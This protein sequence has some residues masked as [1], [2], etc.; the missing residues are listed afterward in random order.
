MD[1][2]AAFKIDDGAGGKRAVLTG[3][4]TATHLGLA[5]DRLASQLANEER[6]DRP[7]RHRP[8]RH[9]R[10]LERAQGDR[11]KSRLG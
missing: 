7:D 6:D 5:P 8:M 11:R 2:A 9:L 10:R 1:E 3:D 4:W